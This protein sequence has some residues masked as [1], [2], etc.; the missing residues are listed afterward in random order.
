MSSSSS[1]STPVPYAAIQGTLT[2][3]VPPAD[4]WPRVSVAGHTSTVGCAVFAP[5]DDTLL[6]TASGDTTLRL[7]RLAGVDDADAAAADAADAADDAD[8]DDDDDDDDGHSSCGRWQCVHVIRDHQAEVNE[9]VFARGNTLVLSTSMDGTVRAF[10][11]QSG[12]QQ[13]CINVGR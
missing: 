8:D 13:A 3:A 5:G 12:V 2:G 9:C 10:D 1:C 4:Q 6:V 7:W 11:V